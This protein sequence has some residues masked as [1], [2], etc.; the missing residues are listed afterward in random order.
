MSRS[1]QASTSRSRRCG[2]FYRSLRNWAGETAAG[3]R[4]SGGGAACLVLIEGNGDRAEPPRG[5]SR[6]DR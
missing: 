4:N 2:Q 1:P 3:V 5:R 6:I